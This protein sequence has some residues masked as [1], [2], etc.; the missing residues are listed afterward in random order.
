MA[1]ARRMSPCSWV[2]L[3]RGIYDSRTN[4]RLLFENIS[5]IEFRIE[6]VLFF[7]KKIGLVDVKITAIAFAA[8]MKEADAAAET[9]GTWTI[10][11]KCSITTTE[12]EA[13]A[14]RVLGNSS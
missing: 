8:A 11:G 4:R 10:E 5:E 12:R 6:L 3:Y 2:V 13:V 1:L 14:G 9:R 7:K